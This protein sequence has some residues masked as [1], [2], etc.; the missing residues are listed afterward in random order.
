MTNYK[1][2]D[3]FRWQW[4]AG[5]G[6][7]MDRYWCKAGIAIVT[8]TG[9]LGDIYWG[10]DDVREIRE[11]EVDLRY[12][13][14]LNDYRLSAYSDYLYYASDDLISLRHSNDTHGPIYIRKGAKRSKAVMMEYAE[15]KNGSVNDPLVGF[16]G[17]GCSFGG[18]FFGGY[19]RGKAKSG[20]WR[21]YA[22]E[23]KRNLLK[24]APNL[25]GILF[26]CSPFTELVIPPNSIIY[27]DPPYEGTTKY[28]TGGFDHKEFWQWCR[29]KSLEGHKVFVSEYN[30]P[31]DF[32]CVW[33][34]GVT[35]NFDSNRSSASGRI[36]KLFIWKGNK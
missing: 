17:F 28:A 7:T 23:T 19:A 27:C 1:P 30:A 20:E 8:P 22:A 14:N 3:V 9:V 15:L 24:Q 5:F 35:A 32:E 4:K 31:D 18:K 21:N 33:S 10:V 26:V 25:K 36:E 6:P 29:E 16:A 2:M 34:K 12:Q 11:M 13:G